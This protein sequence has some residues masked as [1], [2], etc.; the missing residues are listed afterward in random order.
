M[1]HENGFTLIELLVVVAIIGLLS[2]IV[3]ASISEARARARDAQRMMDMSQIRAAL[4]MYYM[5]NGRY[6]G[7]D[8]GISGAPGEYLGIGDNI[9][10]ALAPYLNPVPRDPLHDGV[11][12]FYSY[13][14]HHAIDLNCSD[15]GPFYAVYGA[16]MA[17]NRSETKGQVYRDTCVGSNLNHNNADF[18]RALLPLP[19]C[20]TT[21]Y[22]NCN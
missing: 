13:D 4:E 21:S 2:S 15:P 22:A 20:T 6:P 19:P 3:L 18:N 11:V 5:D 9:D 16:T 12:Y 7:V 10:V 8:D 1:G 14:A 17:F